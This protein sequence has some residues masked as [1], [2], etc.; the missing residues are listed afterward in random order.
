MSRTHR[1]AWNLAS[2]YSGNSKSSHRPG[3][4]S[5]S[6]NRPLRLEVLEDRRLLA[7]TVDTLLDVNDAGDSLTTLREAIVAAPAGETIDFSVTGTIN[8]S[9][10]GQLT[11]DKSLAIDG[12]GAAL[13][14]INAF[15]PTPVSNN[16]DGARVFSIS[17]GVAGVLSDVQISG[18]TLTGGD[19]VF[20]SGAIT[21]FENLTL[22]QM[23]FSGNH[24]QS[25]GG[26]VAHLGAAST[27]APVRL[28]I[29]NSTFSGNSAGFGG[30]VFISSSYNPLVRL[31][32]TITGSTISGNSA[33][34]GG[35]IFNGGIAG[36]FL[37][38]STISGNSASLDGG[39]MESRLSN[40]VDQAAYRTT[41]SNS[42]I[43][44]NS[45]VQFGGGI[46]NLGGLTVIRH[47]TITANTAPAT[48]GSG[49][50]SLSNPTRTEVYSSIIAG[51]T[52]SD[53]DVRGT[54]GSPF[55]SLGYNVIGAGNSTGL[56]SQTGDQTGISAASLMLGPL[57]NHGGP[58]KTHALLA[59]SPAINAGDA[60]AVAGMGDVPL[61]DQRGAPES[62]VRGGRIDVG[63]FEF[64]DFTT[65]TVTT[66]T[67]ENN[68]IGVGGVSLREAIVAANGS[69]GFPLIQFDASLAGTMMLA[70]QLPTISISML[71]AGLGADVLTIQGFDPT[72]AVKNGDGSR[73]F[74]IDNSSLATRLSVAISSLT[75]TG[76]DVS[77]SGGAI[78]NVE[79]LTLT[80]SVITGNAATGSGGGLYNSG[81]TSFMTLNGVA[82]HNNKSRYGGGILN[83]GGTV[84]ITGGAIND[85]LVTGNGGGIQNNFG[86]LAVANSTISGN[87]GGIAGGGILSYFD[88]GTTVSGSTI[89][90]N[91]AIAGGGIW[92]RYSTVTVTSSTI[93]GNY[94]SSHGGGIYCL[95]STLNLKQSTVA[96][97]RT[98]SDNN[99]TGRGGGIFETGASTVNLEQTIVAGNTRNIATRDDVFG[100]AT[101]IL[102]V[103]GANS[104]ATIANSGGN[105]I[106]TAAAPLNP[107]LGP[108][109]DNGGSTMTHAL[110]LGSVAINSGD[111]AISASTPPFDQR[112]NP[113][114][115]VFGGRIDIGALEFQ[116]PSPAQMLIVDSLS[117]VVD[118]NHSA[119]NLSLRE[120][121]KI[122]N[123]NYGVFDAITFAATLNG[124]TINLTSPG[125]LAI[126][127]SVSMDGP[128]ASR[129]TI[130]AFDPTPGT[131]NGDGSRVL[132][133]AD[134]GKMADVSISGLTLTG[135]DVN[136]YG[137]AILTGETLTLSRVTISGSH[138]TAHGGGVSS[139]RANLT[140]ADSELSG[141]S[142][143]NRGGA[144]YSENFLTAFRTTISNSTINDNSADR[145][146]G[147]FAALDEVAISNSTF[148]G[149]SANRGGGIFFYRSN[150]T[151]SNST[152]S[153]NTANDRGGGI[154]NFGD[155]AVIR[156]STITGNT[157]PATKGS[158]VASYAYSTRTEVES[159]IIAGNTNSDV[160][161]IGGISATNNFQ[162]NGFN[163]IG[164]GNATGEF[165]EPGDQ[166]GVANPQL[167]ALADNGG[168]TL[169]H[170]LLAGSSA[171][172]SG[173]PAMA[174]DPAEF[175]QRGNPFVRVFD[176]DGDATARI[177]IGAYE[178]QTL[179]DSS[180]IVDTLIDED[181][182][183]YAAGDRSIREAI[184]LAYGSVGSETI[185][186]AAALTVGG[187]ATIVLT[188]GELAIRDEL[189]ISGP[190]AELL[191]IDA[192]GNDP[193]PATNNADGSRVFNIDDADS[194][195]FREVEIA[196]LALTGGDVSFGGGGILNRENLTLADSVITGNA[197]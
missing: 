7:I 174:F 95:E 133:I 85:N 41:I 150:S 169:T 80:S 26:G 179:A 107:L 165:V 58:T 158:G 194:T 12:P 71:I 21:N 119:G 117:D 112:G 97:N 20:G 93:S 56:F 84:S 140:I 99:G 81:A 153:G 118:G 135:G 18:L 151:V 154:E 110:L 47:T 111:P 51:N 172:D 54:P 142:A 148:S 62:R 171:I 166:S 138:A 45:A 90:G 60:S 72:P 130:K 17:D 27:P 30:G 8:L 68:G 83:Q 1:F 77:G 115:R 114:V 184:D 19:V 157:A 15:D 125:Q 186:F 164:M 129:L 31:Q 152:I 139:G 49:V 141:N 16:G 44:G 94:S 11:I 178:R 167:G 46:N 73:I 122:A 13:L 143:V 123:D 131:K 120:A 146:G 52:N 22:D 38:D 88:D 89:S 113:F 173:N 106:G 2:R 10:L 180:F 181:D 156:H 3:G 170:A 98:D 126:T 66:L 37:A 36:L 5:R 6:L 168:A 187:P 92:T 116:N 177:D 24:T 96:A 76:G 108:L 193:T 91:S 50:A 188:Q 48:R 147:I 124:G 53:I 82:V 182:G 155:I 183:D 185:A 23:T 28:T 69:A 4:G 134:G 109:A 55:V 74:N 59:G 197:A 79:N 128:G 87:S 32:T 29:T 67:D 39:G 195:T 127:D 144:I 102:S 176:S 33:G 162:S 43:S 149:N 100:A 40:S 136:G 9:S 65:I 86:R 14:T 190:G 175:D 57:A 78:R 196:G 191:T 101:A 132:N 104:G 34:T 137:G 189:T 160:D 192:S 63:A 103:I 64:S 61:F 42:T 25:G 161:F 105:F 35:G 121:I 145:G 70:S 163:L 159:S 75:I